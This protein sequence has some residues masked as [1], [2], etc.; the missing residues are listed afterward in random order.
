MNRQVAHYTLVRLLPQA[1]AG[2]F[3]NIGVVLVCPALRA[4]D[5]RLLKKTARVTHFFPEF[6]G[7]LYREVRND[8]RRELEHLQ[9]HVTA[10]A[11]GLGVLSELCRPRETMIRYA[12]P[13]TLFSTGQ[14]ATIEQLMGRFV[15]RD[16]AEVERRREQ[17]LNQHIRATLSHSQFANAFKEDNVGDSNFHVRLPFVHQRDGTTLA[18]I[19]PL[20]LTQDEPQK[21]YEHA[22]PWIQKLRRLQR[23]RLIPA[24]ALLIPTERT[25]SGDA[26]L[27]AAIQ[28]VEEELVRELHARVVASDDDAAILGFARE[29]VAS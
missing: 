27:Q 25:S 20:D 22:D 19:K 29:H 26:Q 12:A 4:F 21:I 6:T 5:F 8:L 23:M 15:E 1:D 13:R 18:A 14:T 3:V 10:G 17:V 11:D 2:E 16:G 9:Q 28:A 24:E 7:G